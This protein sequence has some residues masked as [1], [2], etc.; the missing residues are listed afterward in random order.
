MQPRPIADTSRSRSLR[1]V[2]V[3]P[4]NVRIRA[5][6]APPSPARPPSPPGSRIEAEALEQRCMLV[7][8]DRIWQLLLKRFARSALK[9]CPNSRPYAAFERR[10]GNPGLARFDS[11]AARQLDRSLAFN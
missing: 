9:P 5:A 6:T 1:R 7:M 4:F 10:A 2:I 11:G 8:V 3:S